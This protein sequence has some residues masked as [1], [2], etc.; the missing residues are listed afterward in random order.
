[1]TDRTLTLP[2]EAGYGLALS[3]LGTL[4]RGHGDA[5][6]ALVLHSYALLLLRTP[7]AAPVL[8]LRLGVL[9]E[10]ARDHAQLGRRADKVA[11]LTRVVC[12]LDAGFPDEFPELS[13][14]Y[15]ELAACTHDVD[16]A[17]ALRER[18]A[19]LC[20]RLLGE[21]HPRTRAAQ[22]VLCAPQHS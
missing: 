2:P 12:T 22:A 14:A 3:R 9:L 17:R 21:D 19:A 4:A 10:I 11:T 16:R 6:R 1:M 20:R 5:P 13:D 7:A 15:F 18:G 8:P